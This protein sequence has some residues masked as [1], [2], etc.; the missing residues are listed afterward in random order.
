MRIEWSRMGVFASVPLVTVAASLV[1]IH[2][3]NRFAPYLPNWVKRVVHWIHTITC[4]LLAFVAVIVLLPLSCRERRRVNPGGG[5]PLLL[6]HGYFHD[7]SGWVYLR[8][9]LAAAGLGP[10]YV[11]HLGHPMRSIHEH[12]ETLGACARRIEQE[13][14]RKDLALVGHSMGG[15]VAWEYATKLAPPDTVTDIVTLGSPLAGTRVAHLGIG[16]SARDMEPGSLFIQELQRNIAAAPHIR[17]Y[18]I[19]VRVDHLVIPYGSAFIGRGPARQL[20][21]E[22]LGHLGLLFSSR[23]AR[24]VAAWLQT[25]R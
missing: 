5:R 7:C 8:R 19:G 20:L 13:T 2:V 22:D 11:L 21:I 16:Q 3:L 17:S 10:I 25:E 4:E 12:A 24:Q 9:C 15:L 14:G 1:A 23:V 18:Q 6:V